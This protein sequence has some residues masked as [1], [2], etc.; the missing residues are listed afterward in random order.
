MPGST[1][2]TGL[3][4]TMASRDLVGLGDRAGAAVELGL[5]VL[6]DLVVGVFLQGRV[7]VL[8]GVGELAAL[9]RELGVEHVAGGGFLPSRADLGDHGRGLVELVLLQLEA[10]ELDQRGGALG[11]LGDA[12]EELAGLVSGS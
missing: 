9:E 1:S 4:R 12:A 8:D 2:L 7:E 11:P 5:P 6:D 3:S 10:G